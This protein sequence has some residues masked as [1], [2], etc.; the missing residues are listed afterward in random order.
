MYPLPRG[1]LHGVPCIAGVLVHGILVSDVVHVHVVALCCFVSMTD[2]FMYMIICFSCLCLYL[3][4][5]C[6]YTVV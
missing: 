5:T 3:Q 4:C 2:V 6:V 1:E